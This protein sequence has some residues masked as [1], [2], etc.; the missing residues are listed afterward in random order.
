MIGH[1]ALSQIRMQVMWNRLISVVEEQA[2]TLIRT[3]FCTATREGGDLSAGVF[4]PKGRML[5]QA[6]TGTPG[7][8]NSMANGVKHFLAKYP[9]DSMR[10]GDHYITNDPWIAS[11]HL[12]DFMIVTPCFHRGR[13]V[14]L[15]SAIVH[16]VDVGGRGYIATCRQV[17]EEG[18]LIPIA[19]LIRAGQRNEILLDVIREN[20]REPTQVIGDLYALVACTN[21]GCKRLKGMMNELDLDNLDELGGYII[22]SS[23]EATLREI[24]KIRKGTYR[25]TLR[26]DGMDFEVDI[27]GAVTVTDDGIHVD[28]TGTGPVSDYGI[29][30]VM[31]YTEAYTLYGVSC[32]VAPDI[33]QNAGSLEPIR[34]TAPAGCILNAPRPWPVAARHVLGHMLPDVVMGCLVQAIPDRVIG[35]SGMTWNPHIRGGPSVVGRAAGD[36]D[37]SG[38]PEFDVFM[39]NSGGMGARAT[40]D[41]LSATAFPS[42]V[43]TTPAEATET[44]S[45]IIVWRKEYRP[46]SGGAGRS[47][48]GVGQ[49]LE[50]GGADNFPFVA[51]V[52]LDKVRNPPLGRNGGRQG[53]GGHVLLRS[54][55][56]LAQKGVHRIPRGDHLYLELPGGGGNGDPLEREPEKV[57]EDVLDELVSIATARRE[58]GVVVREDG[59][60]DSEATRRARAEIRA[61]GSA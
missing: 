19:P 40:K 29:N 60:L 25:Y 52:M 45:P 12:H 56:E 11:G 59:T 46:D 1:D 22:D 27:V 10:E 36:V 58:Y 20:V 2:Q 50:I 48:G 33:P 55:A 21:D 28:Y 39:I 17:Y 38:L 61:S 44:I 31:N 34:I 6:V 42:G 32:I 37:V 14:A 4:D 41:G 35:E 43:R 16:V 53:A 49:I 26:S 23:R 15:F 13:P 24:R 47:R 30:V 54:G 7:H 51:S 3:A 8:V 57:V 5:A 9:I 18:L